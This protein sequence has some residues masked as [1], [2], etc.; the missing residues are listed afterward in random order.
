MISIILIIICRWAQKIFE[1][2]TQIPKT[3]KDQ[4]KNSSSQSNSEVSKSLKKFQK[5]LS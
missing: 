1:K 2:K 3:T 5:K 4:K